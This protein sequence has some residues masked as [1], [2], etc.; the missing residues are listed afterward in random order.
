MPVAFSSSMAERAAPF[1]Y[2]GVQ[3]DGDKPMDIRG[4]CVHH[5]LAVI[6]Y[7][8]IHVLHVVAVSH[9]KR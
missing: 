4:T 2:L 3:D 9:G 6:G 8:H 7:Q 1:R 5:K